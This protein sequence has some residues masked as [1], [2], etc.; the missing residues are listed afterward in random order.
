MREAALQVKSEKSLEFDTFRR[1]V[2][3]I[4]EGNP[5]GTECGTVLCSYARTPP[6]T[7]VFTSK[8]ELSRET[9]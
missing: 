3:L 2:W 1:V 4:G 7:P 6:S 5:I 8:G 9:P